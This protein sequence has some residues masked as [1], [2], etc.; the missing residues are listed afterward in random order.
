VHTVG[1]WTR[2]RI[3]TSAAL[4]VLGAG[5]LAVAA[6]SASADE[7]PPVVAPGSDPAHGTDAVAQLGTRLDDVAAEHDMTASEL[8][9]EFLTDATLG[10]DGNEKLFYTEP[11]LV[12]VPQPDADAPPGE[13]PTAAETDDVVFTLHSKPDAPRTI[14]LD[15]TGETISGYGWTHP[16]IGD[17]SCYA[18]PFTIDGDSSTFSVTEKNIIQSVWERVSEDYAPWDVDVTTEEPAAADLART[19]FLDEAFGTRALITS[20]T[21]VCPNGKTVYQSVCGS[22]GGVAYVGVFNETGWWHDAY[23]P[24]FVFNNALANSAK[25]IAEAASHEVGHNLGLDHD[26]A[27]TGCGSGGLSPCGYYYGQAMWAPI[28]G[29]GYNKPVVQWSKGEYSVADNTEDDFAIFDNS[30]LDVRDDDHGD[31]KVGA[32][33]VNAPAIEEAGMISDDDDVDVFGFNAG[34]GAATFAV[35][36]TGTSPNL[37]VALELRDSAYNVVTSNDPAAAY[38]TFDVATGLNATITTTLT[39]GRYYLVVDGVGV[40]TSTNGYTDYA[41]LG[42]YELTGTVEEPDPGAFSAPGEPT[43]V[44][45]YPRNGALQVSWTGPADEGTAPVDDYTVSVYAADGGAATGVTGLT[46]RSVGSAT[47]NLFFDGLTNGTT[48]LVKV[49]AHSDDGVSNESDGATAVPDGIAPTTSLTAP[50]GSYTLSTSIPVAFSSDDEEGGSGLASTE[51]AGRSGAY[52][53]TLGSVSVWKPTATLTPDTFAGSY[54]YTYCFKA[55]A[56]DHA[57]NVD[58]YTSERCTA[59]PLKSDQV[60]YSSGWVAKSV[61]GAYKNTLRTTTKKDAYMSRSSIKAKRVALVAT[62]CSTCG[63]VKVY[64]NGV[65]K[66]AVNLWASS[67]KRKQV[68]SLLSFGGVTSGTLKLVVASSGKT[69]SIEGLGVSKV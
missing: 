60:A 12:D 41:S 16:Y 28:M 1:G 38:S 10:V 21:T 48:Y 11:A 69:V 46:T 6:P 23:Q 44:T 39:A 58:N 8:A 42:P 43:D 36:P 13:A 25:N 4:L 33:N 66:G 53:A 40:G 3:F 64:W 65:Y 29:V 68:V 18:D 20:A 15:F 14:Y 2:I 55:R 52:S 67:T 27:T 57:D 35:D 61:T 49:S 9:H 50:T 30:E 19:D 32:T 31:T 56:K 34:A 17:N 7:A 47:T 45:L 62:K 51:I 22:C 63:S 37:D 24:A 5:S 26:G 59:V 54:G